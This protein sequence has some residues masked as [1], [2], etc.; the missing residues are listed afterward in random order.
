MEK[1]SLQ[2][3]SVPAT[4]KVLLKCSSSFSFYY[5]TRYAKR[6]STPTPIEVCDKVQFSY[7]ANPSAL[8]NAK[9]TVFHMLGSDTSHTAIEAIGGLNLPGGGGL[10]KHIKR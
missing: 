10:K 7:V 1:F 9:W 3:I 5:Q 4:W 6:Q 2:A 8:R